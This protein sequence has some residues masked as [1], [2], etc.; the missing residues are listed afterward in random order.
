MAESQVPYPYL[1][2][3]VDAIRA[4]LS[5][6]RF[7]AYLSKGGN[8]TGYALALYLYNARLAKAFLYPLHVVEVTLRNAIDG[9]LVGRYGQTW[10]HEPALRDGLLTEAGRATLDKAIGRAGAGASRGQII[11]ELTFDFWSHLL[12]P[13]YHALWRTALN[14]VFPHARPPVG[15]HEVQGLARS[16]NRFRNRVAHHEPI[17]DQNVGDLQA[18]IV[19]LIAL[20]CPETAAWTRHHTTIGHV[21]RTRPRNGR[22]HGML[23]SSKLA[24]DFVL[25]TPA[26]SLEE[27]MRMLDRGRPVAICVGD[28]GQAVAAFSA[29]D[30]TRYILA[31]A[32]RNAGLFAPGERTVGDMLA[33][34]DA[35]ARTAVMPDDEPLALA[36]DMLRRPRVDILVGVG[37]DDGRPTGTIMRAHRRY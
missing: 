37:A 30:I 35:P 28:D 24:P 17:L 21:L 16:I 1:P 34:I 14:I 27:V 2:A 15:R 25:A 9:L 32:D 6:P 10:P 7:G 36:V 11:A 5:E 31:D 20:R 29:L 12:R 33:E 18:K 4:S 3:Q 22:G 13:E 26:S 19:E 8:D 23:L